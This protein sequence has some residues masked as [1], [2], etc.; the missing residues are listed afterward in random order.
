MQSLN[1]RNKNTEFAKNLAV[2][3][4]QLSKNNSPYS[5]AERNTL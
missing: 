4:K 2:N 5:F 3:E 1:F